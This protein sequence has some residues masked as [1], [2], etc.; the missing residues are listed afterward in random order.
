VV[1]F[2]PGFPL[3]ETPSFSFFD[4][5]RDNH[6]PPVQEVPLIFYFPLFNSLS[7]FKLKTFFSTTLDAYSPQFCKGLVSVSVLI[8]I[9]PGS[10]FKSAT[11]EDFSPFFRHF[12]PRPW[13]RVITLFVPQSSL[14]ECTCFPP[15][16]AVGN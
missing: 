12:S 6:S 11:T 3:L 13:E 4:K 14:S 16:P 1:C 5:V 15:L 9:S 7:R 2:L 10:C 8:Q